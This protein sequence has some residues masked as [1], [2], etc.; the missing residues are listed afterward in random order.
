MLA[1]FDDMRLHWRE[2]GNPR[3]E[4]LVLTHPLGL[5]MRIWDGV[6]PL[7]PPSLRVI[8]YDMRGH[9]RSDCPVPP[10]RMG[11]L[12]HDAERLL[13]HLGLRDCVFLGHGMGGLVAQGL[14]VKRLDQIRAMVLSNTAAKLGYEGHWLSRIAAVNHQGM[15]AES[16]TFAKL[17]SRSYLRDEAAQTWRGVLEECRPDGFIGCAHAISGTDFY[18][19]TAT[20]TLPTLAIAATE[21]A[22]TP[23]DLMRE[24][25]DLIL[26]SRFH[27]MRGAGHLAC[28][29]RPA[30]YADILCEFLRSI[31]HA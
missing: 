6:V 5:D 13:D 3:G 24:T 1:Y 30:Q 28:V 17:F 12:I 14:A 7:L 26:G 23:P 31:G 4:A 11:T 25:A 22:I 10:Y 2:D 9:G 27:L 8:R 19:P 15:A 16:G 21:D 29:E 18:T 20:L